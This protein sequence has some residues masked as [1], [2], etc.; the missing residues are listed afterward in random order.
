MLMN[1]TWTRVLM[2]EFY[3]IS[4]SYTTLNIYLPM[5]MIQKVLCD[6]QTEEKVMDCYDTQLI[7]FNG[8]KFILFI[9]SLTNL[10]FGLAIEW[11]NPY[12][13][14]SSKHSSWFILLII[15]NFPY[16]LSMKRKYMMLSMMMLGLRQT[17]WYW[18]L[19]RFIDR[20]FE[21]VV[22]WR[23]WGVW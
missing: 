19:Y 17:K 5:L 1:I 4:Q 9:H 23:S 13:N 2:L 3:G 12:V 22:G 18:C 6:M 7:H 11:M 15:Y 14:L 8:W 10:R 21:I 16:W 20:R